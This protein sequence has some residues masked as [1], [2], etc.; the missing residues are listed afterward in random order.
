VVNVPAAMTPAAH[1]LIAV[2]RGMRCVIDKVFFGIVLSPEFLLH[3]KYD[4]LMLHDG[5]LII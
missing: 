2:R 4:S 1:C 5:S 3:L